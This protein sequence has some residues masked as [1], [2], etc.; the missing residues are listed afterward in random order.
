[1]ELLQLIA[2]NNFISVN[3]QLIRELGLA[4]AVILG[5]LCSEYDYW[6]TQDKLIDGNMFFCSIN[7]LQENTGL[8]EYE[9]RKAITNLEDIGILKTEL[10]GMPATRH[11]YIDET[12]ILKFLRSRSLNFKDQDPENLRI[13]N[14]TIHKNKNIKKSKDLDIQNSG[15]LRTNLY[16]N[17]IALID[18]FIMEH[19]CANIRKLLIQHLDMSMEQK[20]IRGQRQYKGI[21]NKLEEIHSARFSYESI[22][23]YS[24]EHGYPTFYE[25]SSRKKALDKETGNRNVPVFTEEDEEK[26]D[27]FVQK[28]KKE[29]KQYAF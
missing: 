3:K 2:S 7:K 23:K 26:R 8:N 20:R 21:L 15:K 11:F 27:K 6:K 9:Q 17:C 14:N 19:Q 18:N 13:N 25:P 22:I 1:M 12:Q 24:I 4:E 29:G 28:L 16:T 5:E 10:K